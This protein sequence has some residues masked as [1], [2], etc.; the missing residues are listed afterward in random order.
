MHMIERYKGTYKFDLHPLS[1]A[2]H[3][4]TRN[5]AIVYWSS[6]VQVPQ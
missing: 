6:E 2:G 5:P 1:I 3:E 4:R